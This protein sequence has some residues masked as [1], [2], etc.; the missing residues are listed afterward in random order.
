[1]NLR[2]KLILSNIALATGVA[3]SFCA[4]MH[5]I[6]KANIKDVPYMSKEFVPA[7]GLILAGVVIGAIGEGM[8]GYV[9]G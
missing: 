9:R 4:A 7:Y 2:D 3:I 6:M 1:M 8:E 5:V